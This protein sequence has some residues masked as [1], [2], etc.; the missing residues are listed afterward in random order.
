LVEALE[1]RRVLSTASPWG[2][3]DLG[4]GPEG[5]NGE[6]YV[7]EQMMLQFQAGISEAERDRIL[8]EN[9]ATVIRSYDKIDW[10]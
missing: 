10:M 8:S 4:A 5:E 6:D 3:G 2:G 9:G 1:E 7:P